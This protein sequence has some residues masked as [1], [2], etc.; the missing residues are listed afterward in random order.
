LLLSASAGKW[1]NVWW[2]IVTKEKGLPIK[3]G[4]PLN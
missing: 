1:Y 2:R 3:F 4:M